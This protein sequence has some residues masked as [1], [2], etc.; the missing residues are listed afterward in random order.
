MQLNPVPSVFNLEHMDFDNPIIIISVI[1]TAGLIFYGLFRLIRFTF[2]INL[3]LIVC[4]L[5]YIS[6][7]T[8]LSSSLLYYGCPILLINTILYVFFQKDDNSAEVGSKYEPM[9]L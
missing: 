4:T 5:Y 6:N 7:L 3:L 8:G 9:L 1:T 2:W